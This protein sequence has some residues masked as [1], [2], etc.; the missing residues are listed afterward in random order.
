MKTDYLLNKNIKNKTIPLKNGCLY[1]ESKKLKLL[2]ITSIDIEKYKN[3]IL[4]IKVDFNKSGNPYAD[5]FIEYR[6][7]LIDK[8]RLS[9]FCNHW[10]FKLPRAMSDADHVNLCVTTFW[11]GFKIETIAVR[12]D[13]DRPPSEY[14]VAE[15][16]TSLEGLED[17]FDPR[18][19]DLIE[20]DE[21]DCRAEELR[22]AG[23][24]VE[25]LSALFSRSITRG[26]EK[27]WAAGSPVVNVSFK[28]GP[29]MLDLGRIPSLASGDRT[30]SALI[31][32]PLPA[33]NI[34]SFA[35]EY[36]DVFPWVI[37]T[38]ISFA[39]SIG[40]IWLPDQDII[41]FD[42]N[43]WSSSW[44]SFRD[45]LL[46]YIQ[47]ISDYNEEIKNRRGDMDYPIIVTKTCKNMGHFFYNELCGVISFGA[48][49]VGA[50]RFDVAEL[51]DGWIDCAD[52]LPRDRFQVEPMDPS[53]LLERVLR[54]GAF[55]VR[56]TTTRI[57]RPEAEH[58]GARAL[59]TFRRDDPIRFDAFA[60]LRRDRDIL[61]VNLR[62]HNKSWARQ[63]SGLTRFIEAYAARVDR[64]LAVYFDGFDDCEDVM[65]DI[66]SA[67]PPGIEAVNGLG[68]S[69]CETLTWSYQCDF[70]IGVIGSGLVPLTWLGD[71]PGIC[72]A[73]LQ[74]MKQ[75][76]F[77]PLVR[78]AASP[79]YHPELGTITQDRNA[80]Y[81]N[82]DFPDSELDRLLDIH[83]AKP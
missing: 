46:Q 19:L 33:R 8:K 14:K 21:L 50:R 26:Q 25:A 49:Q 74:H 6:G 40:F 57:E 34:I 60:R 71:R 16:L 24:D 76:S 53:E 62:S 79:L 9:L 56:I 13:A 42:R 38:D 35:Y 63:V 81:S 32:L 3:L 36:F 22:A 59:E 55:P 72:Y 69:M 83:F 7:K 10:L 67:M 43:Y 39:G 61:F 80:M 82:F 23:I 12:P 70:F 28:Q 66:T 52:F 68:V 4:E 29:F 11:V 30:V 1:I 31:G 37:F 51:H 2:N 64:P 5:F 47:I 27:D 48:A 45:V 44:R 15:R 65:S 17:R 58:I 20:C 78:D 18:R 54:H 73:E 77:W 75:M 41:F